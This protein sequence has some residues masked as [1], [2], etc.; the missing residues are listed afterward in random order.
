M[1][2]ENRPG[3]A[4]SLGAELLAKAPADGYTIGGGTISSHAINVSLYSKLAYDPIKDF[5][6]ITML[7]TLPNMLVIHP[8]IPANNVKELIGLAIRRA[9]LLRA[10]TRSGWSC[11]PLAGPAEPGVLEDVWELMPRR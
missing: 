11:G 1:I 6:P 8:S 9:M 5:T 4:G 3:A 10:P 7:A 2:V